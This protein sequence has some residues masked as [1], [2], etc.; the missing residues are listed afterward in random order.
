LWRLI[1]CVGRAVGRGLIL[2]GRISGS[3]TRPEREQ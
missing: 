3:L 1:I 2:S